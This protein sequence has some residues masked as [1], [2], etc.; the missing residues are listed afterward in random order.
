MDDV[1]DRDGEHVTSDDR[2]CQ[3]YC[4]TVASLCTAGAAVIVVDDAGA[5]T[6]ILPTAVAP[7]NPGT[8]TTRMETPSVSAKSAESVTVSVTM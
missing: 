4:V 2:Y 5:S 8:R 7:S 1:T 6:P 3:W